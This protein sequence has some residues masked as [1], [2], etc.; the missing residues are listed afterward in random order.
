MEMQVK[1]LQ[2]WYLYLLS[3]I[4]NIYYEVLIFEDENP[5]I[6][7]GSNSLELIEVR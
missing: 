2:P 4:G 3:S 6:F 7:Y 5:E 1:R